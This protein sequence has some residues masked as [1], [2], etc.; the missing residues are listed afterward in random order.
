M[1]TVLR[2]AALKTLVS[3]AT[4]G[5]L[6][7]APAAGDTVR[8]VNGDAIR[9]RVVSLDAATLTF[10]SESLGGLKL[11]RA[12]VASIHFGDAAPA[13]V[14]SVAPAASA[15][16]PVTGAAAKPAAGTPQGRVDDILGQLRGQGLDARTLREVQAQF[17]LLAEP[18]VGKMF[19]DRVGGLMSGRLNVQDIRKDAVQALDAIDQLE[20]ELGPQGAEALRGYKGILRSF[21]DQVSPAE[22]VR[23]AA[24]TPTAE[25][26]S[27]D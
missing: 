10:D 25:D 1:T 7:V 19:Q 21:V 6:L 15:A 27:P 26:V 12:K 16:T 8:L 13:A 17:P 18:E 24:P 5:L 4:A 14:E 11:D 20:R 23:P 22:E 9:G 2:T 3:A